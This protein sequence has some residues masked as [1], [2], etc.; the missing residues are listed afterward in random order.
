MPLLYESVSFQVSLLED[1]ELLMKPKTTTE[2]VAFS[3]GGV[4]RKGS[5]L[6]LF[7]II[8]TQPAPYAYDTEK[9]Q[10]LLP[11][12]EKTG[13]TDELKPELSTVEKAESEGQ[14]EQLGMA[15]VESQGSGM[16]LNFSSPLLVMQIG[17]H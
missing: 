17:K 13:E 12:S 15:T 1:V 3:R 16:S 5:H 14:G 10:Q 7:F 2:G 4:K 11:V 8:I 9:D 6:V